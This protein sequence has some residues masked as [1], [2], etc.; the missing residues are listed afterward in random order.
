MI[1]RFIRFVSGNVPL[2]L[3]GAAA[4]L[5]WANLAPE[6]YRQVRDLHVWALER[7]GAWR[8]M[9]LRYLVNDIL[10]SLFFALVGKQVWEALRALYLVGRPP[11][12]EDVER[13]TRPIPGL[14][15]T[16]TRQAALT[17]QAIQSRK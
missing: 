5:A 3:L 1:R 15:D 4:G 16:I 9:D 8:G 10:M 12:L 17:A 14:P 2:L 7:G 11:D 13:Y 6:G